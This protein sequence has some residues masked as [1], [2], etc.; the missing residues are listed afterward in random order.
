MTDEPFDRRRKI[1]I[2]EL[3][4]R[5]NYCARSNSVLLLQDPAGR[6]GQTDG[7]E[8]TGFK[9]LAS[10]IVTSFL[11]GGTRWA[12]ARTHSIKYENA[13]FALPSCPYVHIVLTNFFLSL[14][15]FHHLRRPRTLPP[16]GHMEADKRTRG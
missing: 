14:T 3:W 13:T 6:E 9:D 12:H 16:L 5:S 8:R 15:Y 7:A 11:Y 4:P 2:D 1:Q 10:T